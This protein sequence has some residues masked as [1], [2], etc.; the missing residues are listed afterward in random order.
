MVAP[1]DFHTSTWTLREAN[2]HPLY[3]GVPNRRGA[4]TEALRGVQLIRFPRFLPDV[5]KQPGPGLL[6]SRF[7]ANHNHVSF[8]FGSLCEKGARGE[9]AID[10]CRRAGLVHQS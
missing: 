3:Q 9:N 1:F 7:L 10:G 2:I 6:Q 5:V 8:G 4:H